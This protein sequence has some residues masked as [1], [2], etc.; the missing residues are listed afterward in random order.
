MQNI[1]VTIIRIRSVSNPSCQGPASE[2]AEVQ[3]L[4]QDCS[5]SIL[6]HVC[7]ASAKL[8]GAGCRGALFEV[9]YN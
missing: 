7:R 1:P 9:P 4:Q 3:R 8:G 2:A 5:A 6:A